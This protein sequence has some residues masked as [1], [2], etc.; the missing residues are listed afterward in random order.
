MRTIAAT[1]ISA[2]TVQ[3]NSGSL[4][5]TP[6]EDGQVTG[7]IRSNDPETEQQVSTDVFGGE[8]RI[9]APRR[10]NWLGAFDAHVDVR[11]AVPKGTDL[12]VTSGSAD[13][14]TDVELGRVGIKSGSA[15]L[16]LAGARQLSCSSGSGDLIVLQVGD[17]T[18]DLTTG[19]G[20][21]RI[22]RSDSRLQLKTASGDI[23]VGRVTG[24]VEAKTASGDLGIET[25][26][27]S[28][29]ARTA[30][31]DVSIG[32]A[33]PLPA[34]LDVKSVTGTVD[35]TIPPTGQPGPDDPYVSIYVRTA[36]GDIHVSR[37]TG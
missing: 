8:L 16:R 15:D 19:S 14:T 1:D 12:Q 4:T 13:V 31:G 27:A 23:H 10:Q 20:D 28:V 30:S 29:S 11:L 17:G 33:D 3:L 5:I 22:E 9:A 7:E 34:W 37:A 32:V 26:T 35:I 21:I 25:T 36:T 24:Q 6:S 18:A 2:V